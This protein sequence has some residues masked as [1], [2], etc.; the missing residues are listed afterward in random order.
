GNG[1]AGALL[2]GDVSVAQGA[3]LGGHGGVGGNVTNAGTMAPGNSIGTFT[4]H[5]DYAQT[6]NGVLEIEAQADGQADKLVVGGSALLGGSML[7]LAADGDWS[8]ETGYTILTAGGGINGE[9]GAASSSLVFLDPLLDYGSN[10]VTLVL[11]RNDI[12]FASAAASA[13]QAGVAAAADALGWNN[14]VYTELTT[15]D[16]AQAAAAFDALSGEI[17]ASARGMLLE[18]GRHLEQ[19]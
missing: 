19:A 11:R 16:A 7:V 15:L 2:G 5:G 14:P 3:I 9:F 13:N 17:H 8:P 10:A 6:A 1:G 4:I 18:D 12:A